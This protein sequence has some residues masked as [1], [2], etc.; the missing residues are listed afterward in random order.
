MN[1]SKLDKMLSELDPQENKGLV[2]YYTLKRVQLLRELTDKFNSKKGAN[3]SVETVSELINMSSH[4]TNISFDIE[5][6]Q[7]GSFKIQVERLD[8][9]SQKIKKL[10]AMFSSLNSDIIL[11]DNGVL[12]RLDSVPSQNFCLTKVL[13]GVNTGKTQS[14]QEE[15]LT[16]VKIY[17]KVSQ[18]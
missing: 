5:T 16:G 13:S 10:G 1:I 4:K 12:Y 17:L 15:D 9:D 14:F 2:E 18:H 6:L 8:V 3:L 7:V 11:E